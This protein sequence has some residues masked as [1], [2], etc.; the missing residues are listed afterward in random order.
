MAWQKVVFLKKLICDNHVSQ[1]Y[2]TVV[3][4]GR[5]AGISVIPLKN[6]QTLQEST[7]LYCSSDVNTNTTRIGW[8]FTPFGQ[9]IEESLTYSAQW[10]SVY[11]MSKLAISTSKLGYY[12]CYTSEGDVLKKYTVK[13]TQTAIDK[14]TYIYYVV[15]DN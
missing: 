10:E 11:G 2:I 1:S 14:G 4:F 9:E 7:T 8:S 6:L 5:M 15:L 3:K 12:S 13:L